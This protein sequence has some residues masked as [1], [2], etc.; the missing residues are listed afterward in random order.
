MSSPPAVGYKR[1]PEQARWKKGQSGNPSRR[2]P[3]RSISAVEMIDEE[4]LRPIDIVEN[5]VTRRVST[6]EAI[7]LQLWRKEVS[8]DRRALSVRLKYQEFARQN[9]KQRVEITFVDSDYTRALAAG[10]STAS[11]A[12]E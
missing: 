3:A 10:G 2:Y 11:T 1:P 6:L 4:L 9:T 8:G 12:D 5:G 7:V